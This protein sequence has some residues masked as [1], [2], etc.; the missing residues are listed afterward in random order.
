MYG[1]YESFDNAN[2]RRT[3]KRDYSKKNRNCFQPQSIQKYNKTPQK[4]TKNSKIWKITN[5]LRHDSPL[6]YDTHF[7]TENMNTLI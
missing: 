4:L 2:Q 7:Y 1:Y 5:F 6:T 3:H